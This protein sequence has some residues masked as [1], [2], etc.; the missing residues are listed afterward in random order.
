F[1]KVT[2]DGIITFSARVG[3]KSV[4]DAAHLK[5]FTAT[6]ESITF[7]H[8]MQLG[9]PCGGRSSPDGIMMVR[10]SPDGTQITQDVSGCIET[11]PPMNDPLTL[12]N[13][14]N[15]II[16]GPDGGVRDGG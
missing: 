1:T 5:A 15:V 14:V 2:P 16:N 6:V 10:E 12:W 7:R 3:V 4:M 9:F 8:D 13:L 11:G